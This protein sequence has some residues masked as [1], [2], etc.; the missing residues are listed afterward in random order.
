MPVA[1][2]AKIPNVLA[3]R[4]E[5]PAQGAQGVDRLRQSQPRQADIRLAGTGFDRASVG[6]PAGGCS[7]GI[8]MVH[9]PYRGAQPALNDVMAGHID[10][11][12]DTLADLGAAAI[13]AAS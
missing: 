9:V 6:E 1:L 7:A 2:L 5:L 8:K 12:F 11:F 3:V 10:M 13:A 4:N